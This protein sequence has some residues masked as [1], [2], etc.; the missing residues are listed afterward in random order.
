MAAA[1]GDIVHQDDQ[2]PKI[3]ECSND[4]VLNEVGV[5][6]VVYRLHL[7]QA[8][9]HPELNSRE[10]KQVSDMDSAREM[11]LA[12]VLLHHCSIFLGKISTLRQASRSLDLLRP[13]VFTSG[14]LV[15]AYLRLARPSEASAVRRNARAEP[16]RMECDVVRTVPQRP[17]VRD[18]ERVITMFQEGCRAF[19]VTFTK[20]MEKKLGDNPLG[21]ILSVDNKLADAKLADEAD[22][23]KSKGEARKEKRIAA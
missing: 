1:G 12:V 5:V 23:H 3:L 2:A 13:C 4:F 18:G 8:K 9:L 15:H 7:E 22:E 10:S 17:R 19:Q 14:S 20:I 21:P 11:D 6:R 16:A